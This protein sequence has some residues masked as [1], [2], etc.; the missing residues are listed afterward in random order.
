MPATVAITF[1]SRAPTAKNRVRTKRIDSDRIVVETETAAHRS[2]FAM[3]DINVSLVSR[4]WTQTEGRWEAAVSYT[5]RVEPAGAV[6]PAGTPR[7]P[8]P[9]RPHPAE[10]APMTR[11]LARSGL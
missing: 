9:P 5:L 4:I 11:H 8:G 3:S 7:P 1:A 2:S 6:P 10:T